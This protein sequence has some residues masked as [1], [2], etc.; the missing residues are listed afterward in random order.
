MKKDN[1]N[2]MIKFKIQ[3]KDGYLML[4]DFPDNCIFNKVKTGCGATTNAI[5]NN[6]DYVIAVPTTELVENKCFPPKDREGKDVVWSKRQKKAG[7]SPTN[8]DLFALYGEFNQQV[9]VELISFLKKSGKKKIICTYDKIEKLIAIINPQEYKILIDEYHNLLK[10]YS[11]RNKA[12]DGV[13]N[14]YK[15]FR[16]YC[17]LSATPIP[18]DL[19]PEIFQ[20]IPQYI[21]EWKSEE[22]I[23]VYPYHTDKPCMIA[24]KIIVKYKLN[25]YLTV[26]GEKSH[27]A[28]FFINSVRE[29]ASILKQSQLTNDECRIICAENLQN[30]KKLEGFDISS[31][32]D[33]P[34]MFNFIT[35][36]SFE[37]VDY[38]S[39]TGLCFVISNTQK[40]HTLISIDMDIPQIAG[41]IRTRSN[42]FKNK[43][44]HIYNTPIFTRYKTYDIIKNEVENDI[45]AAK[46]RASIFNGDTLTPDARKQQIE[47]VKKLGNESYLRYI[48]N[49]FEVN[50]MVGKLKLYSYIVGKLIYLSDDSLR[51]YYS[52]AGILTAKGKQ[53]EVAPKSVVENLIKNPQFR[54]CLRRFC[55]IMS[56]DNGSILQKEELLEIQARYPFLEEGY[57]KLGVKGLNSLGTIKSIKKEL[58]IP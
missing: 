36:K 25:G 50:D 34:R 31:S 42:P 13:M 43:L 40:T 15:R 8:G 2:T 10:F 51:K 18:Q 35:S 11:F 16:A 27:E 20:G 30:K 6:I 58:G 41:R 56:T 26:N 48:D 12:I 37:G 45:K 14:N 38:Y 5:K 55:Q 39:E 21:A 46:E 33:T 57:K 32:T 53:W 29:I 44:V 19:M 17:F 47:D 9:K 49:R 22:Q 4:D 7:V 24:S 1:A 23:M 54:D 52:N 28:Y 3:E